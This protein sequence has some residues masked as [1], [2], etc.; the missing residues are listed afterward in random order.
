[1]ESQEDLELVALLTDEARKKHAEQLEKEAK[2]ESWCFVPVEIPAGRSNGELWEIFDAFGR[3]LEQGDDLI[4]DL[5]HGF[6]HIPALLLSATQYYTVRK[7]LNLLGLFYGAYDAPD[8]NGVRPIFDLTPLY[9]L[10]EWTYGVRLLRDYRFSA[11]LGV[12]LDRVQRRSHLDPRYQPN[13]FTKLQKVG[14]PL[15]CLEAP[16][17]SG[18]PLEAG[19]EA[20]RALD[21]ARSSE[22]ELQR[23]PPMSEP[24]RELKEQLQEFGLQDPGG[25][26]NAPLTLEELQRQGRLIEGYLESGNL[27]AAANLLREWII[28][29]V[30]F[31]SGDTDNWLDYGKKRKPVESKLGALSKWNRDERFRE[32]LT[33]DQRTLVGLWKKV[34]D[35][36]N[37]LAHAGMRKE[38]TDLQPDTFRQVFD[39]LRAKL[40]DGAIWSVETANKTGDV[41]LVSPLGTTPGALFTAIKKTRPDR[42]LV[43]TSKQGKELVPE[44]LRAAGRE[45]LSPCCAVL[46]DPFN[47]FEEGRELAASH[48]REHGLDW[49]RAKDIVVNLTGGTTCLG[50]TV[51]RLGENLKRMSLESRAVAC[52]N[53]RSPEEQRANPFVEDEIIDIDEEEQ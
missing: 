7:N 42:L 25:K 5:T 17:V 36:R 45:D 22:E 13:K 41:W 18:I 46:D 48:R 21:N 30:I 23:I 31:H 29:A 27:W 6:R 19:F 3:E 26:G 32:A 8:E 39:V 35:R 28:S 49:I 15:Q 51:G 1:M 50:W 24:W 10:T 52:I 9:D 43:V 12:M 14:K 2:E 53:R 37:A 11:P 33:E 44:V 34:S 20:Q 16:L 4:L 40:K 47:G 38:K